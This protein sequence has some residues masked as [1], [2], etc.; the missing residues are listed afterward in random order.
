MNSR[1]GALTGVSAGFVADKRAPPVGRE[2]GAETVVNGGD[3]GE[4]GAELGAVGEVQ[5]RLLV[6]AWP[7]LPGKVRT[8]IL[9]V[10]AQFK[11]SR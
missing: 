7:E 6:E 3:A 10:V 4:G 11:M 8:E 1:R 9:G 5:L 2:R